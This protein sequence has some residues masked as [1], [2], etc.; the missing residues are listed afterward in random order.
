M[1]YFHGMPERNMITALMISWSSFAFYLW[2]QTSRTCTGNFRLYVGNCSAIRSAIASE[3]YRKTEI[4]AAPVHK[5]S[6][7]F[8]L[9]F[10][11]NGIKA[12]SNCAKDASSISSFFRLLETVLTKQLVDRAVKSTAITSKYE[13]CELYWKKRAA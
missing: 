7:S 6:C 4:F 12:V 2:Y 10:Y 1:R 11:A 13:I 5:V 8:F 3:I 9:F